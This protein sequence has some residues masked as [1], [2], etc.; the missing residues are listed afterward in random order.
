MYGNSFNAHLW[1]SVSFSNASWT[2][3][4]FLGVTQVLMSSSP[5]LPGVSGGGSCITAEQGGAAGSCS[6][7]EAKVAVS[8]VE[9]SRWRDKSWAVGAISSEG[10]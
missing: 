3:V 4:T 6:C 9:R 7:R 10:P 1:C 2:P 5:T 8:M